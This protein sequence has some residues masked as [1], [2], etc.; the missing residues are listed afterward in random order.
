MTDH[1]EYFEYLRAR[2]FLGK[3]YR[4]YWLY[5]SLSRHLNGT[6]L[7]V[8]CGIGDMLLYRPNTIGVDVNPYIVDWNRQRGLDVHLLAGGRIPFP[9][10]TFD[11]AI[12]D[13]VLEHI[14]DPTEVLN[15]VRRV[16]KADSVFVVGVPGIKGF[17][18][19]SDHKVFYDEQAL[20]ARLT[21]AGFSRLHTFWMPVRCKWLDARWSY[22]FLYSVFR[23]SGYS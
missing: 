12:M 23:S 9:D 20:E 17:S 2:S 8:G 7:D 14:S 6:A 19:D 15:E 22:Y 4:N 3:L 16:L 1:A 5:P 21:M 18:A 13:N 10:G 11:S